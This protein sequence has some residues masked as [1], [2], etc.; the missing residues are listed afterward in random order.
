MSIMPNQSPR[1]GMSPAART[2]LFWALLI[3][4]A[5]VLW[6]SRSVPGT[7]SRSEALDLIA[8]ITVIGVWSGVW[9]LGSLLSQ[10]FRRNPPPKDPPNRPLG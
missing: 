3:A 7:R 9:V 5:V 2:V 1:S 8:A 10:K 4:L 6:Q